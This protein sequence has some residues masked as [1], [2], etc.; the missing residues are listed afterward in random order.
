MIQI[1][2]LEGDPFAHELQ[3][4]QIVLIHPFFLNDFSK[5]Y[6][7]L[8]MIYFFQNLLQAAVHQKSKLSL[9]L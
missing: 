3:A 4:E 9:G 6:L 2:I 8:L 1:Y 7:E 5:S